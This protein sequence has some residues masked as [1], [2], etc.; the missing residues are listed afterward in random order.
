MPGFQNERRKRALSPFHLSRARVD[1]GHRSETECRQGSS[2]KNLRS[3]EYNPRKHLD[4][5]ASLLLDFWR[6]AIGETTADESLQVLAGRLA[7]RMAHQQG[8]SELAPSVTENLTRRLYWT[9]QILDQ[10]HYQA[11]WEA[12]AGAPR[13]L[14][15]HCPYLAIL[16]KNPE[17]CKIDALLIE[18]LSGASVELVSKLS[19]DSAGLKFCMFRV[20]KERV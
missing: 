11:R 20:I 16:E 2:G 17:L 10:N 3:F 15:G 19:Q 7:D 13:I 9:I 14:L 1:P 12:R 6:E 8:L 18:H 4:L 5:L